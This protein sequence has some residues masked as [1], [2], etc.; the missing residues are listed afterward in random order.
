[1]SIPEPLES[2]YDDVTAV[3]FDPLTVKGLTA[4][5][6]TILDTSATC[7]PRFAEVYSSYIL[8]VVMKSKTASFSQRHIVG[9]IAELVCRDWDLGSRCNYPH[10]QCG[11]SA[12]RRPSAVG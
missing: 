9:A 10:P 6:A 2:A 5:L 11:Y 12:I 7:T 1:M 4:T 3:P 8:L